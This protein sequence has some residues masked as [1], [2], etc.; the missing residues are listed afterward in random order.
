VIYLGSYAGGGARGIG[1]AA[2]RDGVL[3]LD[4][5]VE[6]PAR[7]AF[8]AAAPDRRALYA[9]HELEDGLI[10]GFAIGEDGSL[11][12]RGT[13][14][15]AGAEPCHLSVHPS[16]RYVLSANWGSGSIVVHRIGRGGT[17][18]PATHVV[19]SRKPHAHMVMT[20]PTGRFVLAV[21][22]GAGTVSTYDLDLESGRLRL[23]SELALHHGAGPRHLAFHPRGTM[24]YVVNELDSTVTACGYDPA[25]GRVE[26]RETVRTVPEDVAV[27]NFPS[28]VRVSPDGR[29]VYVGNRGHDSIG[30]LSTEA[31][32]RLLATYPCGGQF[33]RDLAFQGNGRLLWVANQR[34]DTVVGL[35]VDPADGSLG[36]AG[37]CMTMRKPTCVLPV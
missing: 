17:L 27:E 16:G 12:P 35:A 26:P 21:H 25:S 22:L 10:S 9:V 33:P 23:R 3:A 32:L 13:Q 4:S 5:T 2:L 14:P 11:R 34:T 20:D 28:A 29:F 37:Y 6:C 24:V 7:P 31:G 8:L 36:S 19:E 18:G 15:S 1:V 30:V